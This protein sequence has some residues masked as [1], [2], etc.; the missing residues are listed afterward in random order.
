MQT[1]LKTLALLVLKTVP[2]VSI[3]NFAKHAR[4]GFFSFLQLTVA[5]RLALLFTI[6]MLVTVIVVKLLVFNAFPRLSVFLVKDYF[7]STILV[8]QFAQAQRT[9]TPH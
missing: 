4:M 3:L 7:S 5:F 6:Q 1:A 8:F 9:V 2:L